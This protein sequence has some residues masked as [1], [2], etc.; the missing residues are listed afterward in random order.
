MSASTP[1]TI[2]EG[3]IPDFADLAM[4]SRG[5]VDTSWTWPQHGLVTTWLS[6]LAFVM[7]NTKGCSLD[8]DRND[9]HTLGSVIAFD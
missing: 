5:Y 7:L 3:G 8:Q 2:E 6:V 1:A 9:I 4:L